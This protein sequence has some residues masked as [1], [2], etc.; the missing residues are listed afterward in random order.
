MDTAW[1]LGTRT[2]ELHLALTS[3]PDDPAF[4][5]QPFAPLDQRSFYQSLRNQARQTFQLVAD[6]MARLP[7]DVQ[8]IAREILAAESQVEGRYRALLTARLSE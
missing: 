5:P 2:S 3:A 1:L 6:Q 4:A 8:A 7:A